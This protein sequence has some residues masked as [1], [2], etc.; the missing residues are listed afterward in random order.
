MIYLT[1]PYH[2]IVYNSGRKK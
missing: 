2:P 1:C